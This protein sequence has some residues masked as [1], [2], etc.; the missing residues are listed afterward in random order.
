[1]YTGKNFV[2][3]CVNGAKIG[4]RRSA[5]AE[6]PSYHKFVHFVIWNGIRPR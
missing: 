5:K 6:S 2:R 4:D 1:M 3:W